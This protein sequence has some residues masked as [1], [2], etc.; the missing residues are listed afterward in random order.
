MKKDKVTVQ[1]GPLVE[2]LG[3]QLCQAL[4]FF[5]ALSGCDTTSAF[6]SIGKKKGFQTLK[7]HRASVSTFA[8]LFN[9]P[10]QHIT[11]DSNVFKI[12]QRFVILMYARS[13]DYSDVNAAKMDMFFN[14]ARYMAGQSRTVWQGQ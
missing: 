13:S 9:N 11:E 12:I 1:I 3:Q 14:K 10:F 6:K 2:K 7:L 8:E 5:H 4:P